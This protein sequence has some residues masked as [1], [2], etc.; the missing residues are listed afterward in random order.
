MIARLCWKSSNA[1]GKSQGVEETRRAWQT[2]GVGCADAD[3]A[4]DACPVVL[5]SSN[6][7]GNG[8]PFLRRQEGP[9]RRTES[10][11]LK[12]MMLMMLVRC[13]KSSN[14]WGNGEPFLRRQ[15]GP[16]RRTESRELMLMMLVWLCWKSSMRGQADK[17]FEETR[18]ASKTH[19]VG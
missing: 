4:D 17:V 10:D 5:K 6:A 9:G 7:W 15:E 3:D 16:G 1:W 12:M 11:K 18:R 19:G 8:E 14:A 13:W 2:H